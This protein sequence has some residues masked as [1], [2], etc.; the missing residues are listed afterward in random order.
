MKL[1][2]VI[3]IGKEIR[4]VYEYR[5]PEQLCADLG[6][7][8]LLFPMGE[9]KKSIKGFILS[10]A[11]NVAVT[12]NS[13]LSA[14]M[15]RVVRYHEIAH[16]ILHVRTGQLD[17]IHDCDIYD[18]VSQTEYEANLLAAELQLEDED[19]LRTL[20]E[21]E[22]FFSAAA[23]LHVPPQLLDFKCRLLR[24]KGHRLPDTPIHSEG[25]YLYQFHEGA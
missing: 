3:A 6:V 12:V 13:D 22:D 24:E 10:H 1:S 9:A 11:G 16:Y 21:S 25:G 5:D 8:S 20:R 19:V 7:I 17:C 2:T 23:N 4:A 15:I 14:D 18:A